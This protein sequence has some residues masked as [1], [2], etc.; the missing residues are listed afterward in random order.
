MPQFYGSC[1]CR[2]LTTRA[3]AVYM[4]VRFFR[5][6]T[7]GNS[8]SNPGVN[9]LRIHPFFQQHSGSQ[10][11]AIFHIGPIRNVR[12]IEKK[13]RE[14]VTNQN[15]W[16]MMTVQYLNAPTNRFTL[17]L[18][19]LHANESVMASESVNEKENNLRDDSL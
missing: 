5:T 3:S 18:H 1:H 7:R 4:S 16:H 2:F 8:F 9:S 10:S 13:R 19:S 6:I 11:S 15:T 17:F 14:T 12:M